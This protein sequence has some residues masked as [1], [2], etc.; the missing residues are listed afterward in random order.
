MKENTKNR[1]MSLRLIVGEDRGEDKIDLRL[2]ERHESRGSEQ[3]DNKR[4]SNG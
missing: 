1:M 4:R 3:E 2:G